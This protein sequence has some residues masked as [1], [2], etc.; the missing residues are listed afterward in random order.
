MEIKVSVQLISLRWKFWGEIVEWE[1]SWKNYSFTDHMRMGKE[2]R[3]AEE[4]AEHLGVTVINRSEQ[5]QKKNMDGAFDHN[6]SLN[7]MTDTVY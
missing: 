6:H 1:K 7:V 4:R 3:G 5:W 2:S